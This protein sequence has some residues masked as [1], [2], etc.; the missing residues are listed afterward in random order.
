MG[1]LPGWFAVPWY[2]AKLDFRSGQIKT[3]PCGRGVIPQP[4]VSVAA[5]GAA[6]APLRTGSSRPPARPGGPPG[7]RSGSTDR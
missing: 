2:G 6:T 1:G 5:G 3:R 7:C 4:D